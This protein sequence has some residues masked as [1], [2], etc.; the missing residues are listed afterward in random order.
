MIWYYILLFVLT[1][2]TAAF[3]WL[4]KVT[5]IPFV[6]GFLTTGIGY[7]N[8]VASYIPPLEIIFQ[9]FMFIIGFKLILMTLRLL[10]II[11]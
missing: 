7:F 9:G 11:R 2:L 8:F 6:D 10:R 1:L 3:S 5:T 4:P